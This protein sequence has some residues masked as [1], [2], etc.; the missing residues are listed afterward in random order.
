[1]SSFNYYL[2]KKYI[3]DNENLVIFDIGAHNFQD[4]LSLKAAYPR[5][6]VYSFEP[7]KRNIQHF[8]NLAKEQ[9]IKIIEAAVSDIDGSTTFF[10]SETHHGAEWTCSGSIIAP[11]VSN[12]ATG[13]SVTHPA[14]CYNLSGYTVDTVTIKGFCDRNSIT[15]SILH[16]DA[17]GSE[18]KII[19]GI[20]DY[21]PKI[22]FTETCEF[23][24]Y[25]TGTDLQS[26]DKLME[27]LGY[28]I[29]E[30]LPH[31]TLYIHRN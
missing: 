9:G 16:I 21:R 1:M 29:F 8:S 30:R 4:S 10:N 5:S 24:T 17:Q 25:E 12:Y 2:V 28:I 15:P 7:D 22:I 14:I 20:G 13:Q 11:K 31:D 3:Q 19:N 6:T 23:E 27:S 26:F 18:T